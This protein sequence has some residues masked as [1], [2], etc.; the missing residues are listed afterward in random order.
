MDDQPPD[1]HRR[2][3]A[4]VA[5]VESWQRS[6]HEKAT[7][8]R[9]TYAKNLGYFAAWLAAHE[10]PDDAPGSLLAVR[11]ADVE[12]WFTA[13][14]DAG[15]SGA[16]RRARWIA[17]R[18]FY[19]FLVDEDE[20][21]AN[22]MAKVRV[23]RPDVPPPPVLDLDDLRRLL[24]ACQGRDFEERRD[25]AIIRLMAA[26]GTRLTETANL[27]LDDVDLTSRTLQVTRGK[28]GRARVGRF[29]AATAAALDRYLRRRGYHHAA[30]T[31]WLWL[32]KRGHLTGSGINEM[33]KRRAV[34]AGIDHL[35]AHKLRHTFAHLGKAAGLS[36]EDMLRLGGWTDAD[37]MRRYGE[38]RA[39]E[40]ALAAYDHA[41]PLA[42]L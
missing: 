22:P 9:D 33:L 23:A 8:T 41:N 7:L 14:A 29:D 25:T 5:I 27:R 36:D 37:V 12:A 13:L 16:T 10:R 40:R 2:L 18:S 31:P 30:T 34:Q 3:P 35:H 21:D 26:S 20:I 39:V 24:K 28:G 11:R 32:G 1:H 4:N 6:L 38:G 19:G 15:M 42:G 17:L